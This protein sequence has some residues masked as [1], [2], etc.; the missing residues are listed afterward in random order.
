MEG[1]VGVSKD[2]GGRF[3]HKGGVHN[4]TDEVFAC[5]ETGAVTSKTN[6]IPSLFCDAAE[7]MQRTAVPLPVDLPLGGEGK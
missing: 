4:L 3:P 7:L 5:N 1:Q 6:T 2:C